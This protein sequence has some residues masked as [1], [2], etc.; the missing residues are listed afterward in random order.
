MVAAAAAGTAAGAGTVSAVPAELT[1]VV[2]RHFPPAEHEARLSTLQA[3]KLSKLSDLYRAVDTSW[4]HVGD[5]NDSLPS[6]THFR[7]APCLLNHVIAAKCGRDVQQLF[8]REALH[9][10]ADQLADDLNGEVGGSRQADLATAASVVSPDDQVKEKVS[11]LLQSAEV[12]STSDLLRKLR[13]PYDAAAAHESDTIDSVDCVEC[14]GEDSDADSCFCMRLSRHVNAAHFARVARL[15]VRLRGDMVFTAPHGVS[16]K[17]DLHKDHKAEDFVTL[18]ALRFAEAVKG[19]HVVWAPT[20]VIKSV[21]LDDPDPSNRDPNYLTCEEAQASPFNLVL[22]RLASQHN[23]KPGQSR[24]LHVD[25]HGRMDPGATARMDPSDC[26]LGTKALARMGDDKL[27]ARL[28]DRLRQ[29]LQEF[30]ASWTPKGV[31][32]VVNDNPRFTGDTGESSGRMTMSQQG[33]ALGLASV[34]MELSHRLRSAL[35]ADP[36]ACKRMAAAIESAWR[37]SLK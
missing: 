13:L 10:I 3:I 35:A 16:L 36:A 25:L 31:E 14:N 37:A 33:A 27:A 7:G 2:R 9:A 28:R 22:S 20:E 21:L 32:F 34:Q 8:P 1:A 23:C 5:R 6:S 17:R 26:D 15:D 29:G 18:L 19:S 4:H 12:N 11:E 24:V 30:F